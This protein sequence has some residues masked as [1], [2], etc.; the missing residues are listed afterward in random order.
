AAFG[1][2]YATAQIEGYLPDN[3]DQEMDILGAG[4]TVGVVRSMHSQFLEIGPTK[5]KLLG[6]AR[7]SDGKIINTKDIENYRIQSFSPNRANPGVVVLSVGSS[8]DSG[9]TTSAAY[10]VH[11]LKNA[12]KKVAFIKLTGTIFTKDADL[13]FDMGADVSADFGDFGF[14]STYMYSEKELLDL[15][16]SL[17]EAVRPEKPDYVIME[18]ADGLFQRETKMLLNHPEFMT[19]VDGIM[20]SAGD[21]LSAVHGV[22]LL[23]QWGLFPKCISGLFTASPLLIEEVKANINVPVYTIQELALGTTAI[24]I[25]ERKSRLTS[26][27]NRKGVLNPMVAAAK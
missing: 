11:G 23:N 20:F 19:R 15:F 14:P 18:I 17:L 2:R 22:E 25:F 16:E 27:V 9:K 10:L 13:A 3:L 12:G 8:M 21:S 7:G 1:T 6:L 4:G 5:L 26:T 24:E